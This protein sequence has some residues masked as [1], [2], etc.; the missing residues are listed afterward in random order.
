MVLFTSDNGPARGLSAGP[1]RGRKGSAFEGGQRVPAILWWPGM[2]P[3]GT[4]SDELSTSMDLHP[5]FAEMAGASLPKDRVIDGKSIKPILLGEEYAYSPHDRFF[6]QQKGELAAV[7]SGDWKLFRDGKLYNL[8]HDIGEKEDISD[9]NP[10]ISMILH[11][12]M[13]GFVADLKENSRPVGIASG[14]RTLLPR[15]GVQG[16]DGYIPTLQLGKK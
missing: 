6:Y 3:A 4:T 16:E 5:T 2:I 11:S 13:K 10:D 1:L 15:P 8:K 12:M 14:A 7:R 9:Y